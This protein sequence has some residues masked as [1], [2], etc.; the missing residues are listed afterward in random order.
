MLPGIS[1]PAPVAARAA[2][3]GERVDFRSTT[4][5][6]CRRGGGWGGRELAVF[7]GV[8]APGGESD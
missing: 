7:Q 4:A 6:L 5:P 8:P 3:A 1:A 2:A